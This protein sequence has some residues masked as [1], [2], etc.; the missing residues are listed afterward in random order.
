MS[1][2]AASGQLHWHS[3]GSMP[4]AYASP[5]PGRH[6]V[7][8]GGSGRCLCALLLFVGPNLGETPSHGRSTSDGDP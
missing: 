8:D 6:A 4:V 5:K 3:F 1:Q 2:I 7:V